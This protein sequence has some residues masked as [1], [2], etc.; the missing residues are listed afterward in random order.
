MF[1]K[2]TQTFFYLRHAIAIVYHSSPKWT[3]INGLITILRGALPL[4]L[5]VVVQQI[6]DVV[7]NLLTREAVEW[8]DASVYWVIG[9]GGLFFFLNAITGSVAALVRER[10]SYKV[11]DYIQNIIHDKTMHMP[12]A[13]YEDAYYQN[14]FFRALTDATYRPSRIFYGMLGVAQNMLTIL[15]VFSVLMT[16]H[17]GMLPFLV[18][19]G[20][21]TIF[22]RLYYSR[23]VYKLRKTQTEDERQV[24]YFNQLL[25]GKGF[26]KELRVFNLG[27]TFK[28]RYDSLR[29][30]LRDRQWELLLSKTLWEI[31]VQVLSTAA[32]LM[33]F[34]YIVY[35]AIHGSISSGSM[36]MYFLALH[37]GYAILQELLGRISALYED[38]LFLK[39]FFD[40][41]RIKVGRSKG[42]IE[43]FPEVLRN[44]I[45]FRDVGFKY[46]NTDRWILRNVNFTIPVGKTVALVGANGCGKTT[47]V[48][49]LAGL[50]QPNEGGI[51]ADNVNWGNIATADLAQ[52]ISVIFQD[53]MLYNVSARENIRFGNVHQAFRQEEIV[54]AAKNA[55]IHQRFEGLEK[56]YE[57][58]LGTLFKGSEQLSQ[59]EWQRTALARSFYNPSKIIILDEPTSSLDAFTEASLIKHFSEITK[60]RTA[61]IISHRLSTIKLADFVVVMGHQGVMEMG[62][63]D[64]LLSQKGVFYTMVESLK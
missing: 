56:G 39:N 57:T 48:K 27:R 33:I 13:Y 16:L 45:E 15:L 42:T 1:S 46:P 28:L 37:R 31:V 38:N 11:N 19:A 26:A 25:T 8:N 49:L 22:F 30:R 6:I 61:L 41:E 20:I 44:G 10:Q 36:A 54:Q 47:I 9:L 4:L 34:S 7:S 53:F 64:A 60:E 58:T 62:Q 14:I 63:P 59:G 12:Y 24:N 35:K 52:N 17:W 21:P 5:L 40:F 3:M 51:Y 2:L 18:L 32:L 23:R 50:Y 43:K 55:G 29:D